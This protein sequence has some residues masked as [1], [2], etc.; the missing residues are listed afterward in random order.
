M[1]ELGRYSRWESNPAGERRAVSSIQL[2]GLHCAACADIIEAALRRVEGVDSATVSAGNQRACVRWDPSRAHVAA[3]FDAVRAAGYGAS[4]DVAASTR[5][6]RQLEH[7][8]VVWRLFVAAFLSMQVMMLAIPTYVAA[9][10]D[11]SEDLRQLL[12]WGCWVLSVP[13]VWFAGL[14]FLRGAWRSVRRGHIH[15]DVPV[16]LGIAVA[17][18]ASTVA[19]FDPSGPLGPE[20]YFDSLT[21]F[22]AFLWMGR[23]LEIRARHRAAEAL[24]TATQTLPL[25]ALRVHEDG[26]AQTV[27][28]DRLRRGDV[29]RVLAGGAL[30]ADGT[31][32]SDV[33]DVNEAMLTGESTVVSRRRGQGLLAGSVNAGCPF[34]MRVERTGAD[35][36]HE[37]IVALMRETLSQRPSAARLADRIAGPFLWS[38]LLLSAG[39]AAVWS[40]ID[41]PRALWIAVSVLIVTCPCALSLATPATLVAAA[42][43][44]ARRGVLLR[45][46]D[47][48]EKMAWI[49]WIF[50]DKT[51]TLTQD[52]LALE[53]IERLPGRCNTLH[54]SAA[55]ES[56]AIAASLATWSDHP[57]SRA[58]VRAAADRALSV[59]TP[60]WSEVI[61]TPGAGLKGCDVDGRWW[62]LGSAAWVSA[63]PPMRGIAQDNNT[64]HRDVDAPNLQGEG[65]SMSIDAGIEAL[66]EV[67]VDPGLQV[68][69]SCDGAP[70][71]RFSLVETL[72]D[73]A[74]DAIRDL[75]RLGL[76]PALLSGDSMARVSRLADRLGIAQFEAELS[77][78]G[79]RDRVRKAQQ[80]GHRV[81]MVGDGLNDAPV[82]AAADVALAMGHAAL[83]TQ[84]GA[85]AVI[86][87]A[88]PTGVTDLWLSARRTVSLIRQNLLWAALYNLTCIP[89]AMVGWMPPWA[90]GLGMAASS[91]LVLL[92]AQRAA[93]PGFS[94]RRTDVVVA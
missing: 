70:V 87:S 2:S 71:A 34:E 75:Q 66:R 7:R 83:A 15:M 19:T 67:G 21:M 77:P 60:S 63:T 9:P 88:R 58:L 26:Q 55:D 3:L 46:L 29:V 24:E 38:V 49:R 86:V 82:L 11:L 78:E 16:G 61:E 76:T 56:L 27:D 65:R 48:L 64:I 59:A 92:N 93:R 44:L 50:F 22:L 35:T 41:P 30:P 4:P 12:H 45:R 80:A 57:A 43:G 52:R 31:L 89:M 33:A 39:S 72:R 1:A 18:T 85:D 14:P 81:A 68:L 54:R 23:F 47:A 36:R 53:G 20:V 10:G 5:E 62:R 74:A 37:A 94:G 6:L 32:L 25:Q 79:K 13:V 69:L 90:A 28:R 51:G 73:G 17:F 8:D 42:S 84:H 91:L 40:A